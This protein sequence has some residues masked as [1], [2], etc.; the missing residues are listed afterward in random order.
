M[1]VVINVMGFCQSLCWIMKALE[2]LAQI[3]ADATGTVFVAVFSYQGFACTARSN[4]FNLP[5]VGALMFGGNSYPMRGFVFAI[6]TGQ[7]CQDIFNLY[8]NTRGVSG[9]YFL[10]S[11]TVYCDMSL[12]SGVGGWTMVS[13]ISSVGGDTTWAYAS[14]LW[15]STAT[16]LTPSLTDITQN[17]NMKSWAFNSLA[18]SQIRFVFGQPSSANPGY[19]A[20]T[21]AANAAAL[22]AGGTVTTSFAR[23]LFS[24]TVQLVAGTVAATAT[25]SVHATNVD[26][27]YFLVAT[28]LQHK[29]NQPRHPRHLSSELPLRHWLQQCEGFIYSM[30]VLVN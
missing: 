23:S 20:T 24:A 25:G 28:K 18:F 26:D 2:T 14:N 3:V 19:V 9:T 4:A 12:D 17:I 15:T 13:M 29:C 11:G 5:Q 22:F 10:R 7:S 6:N 1:V 27:A 8:P 21:S 16:T 30:C